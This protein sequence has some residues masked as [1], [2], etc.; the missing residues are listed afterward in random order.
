MS[1]DQSQTA[2]Q[3]CTVNDGTGL[4]AGLLSRM[5]KA[6]PPDATSV[7]AVSSA[8]KRYVTGMGWV[9]MQDGEVIELID[10]GR[11]HVG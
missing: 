1:V 10:E 7:C 9:W 6:G 5:A 4:G 2:E 3:C 11:A 8:V